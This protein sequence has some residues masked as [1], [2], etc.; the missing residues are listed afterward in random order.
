MS[1]N[2]QCP[3]EDGLYKSARNLGCHARLA[4]ALRSVTGAAKNEHARPYR[5]LLSRSLNSMPTK[6]LPV[7]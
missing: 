7:I 4:Q 6:K 5:A 3:P 2:L 1:L